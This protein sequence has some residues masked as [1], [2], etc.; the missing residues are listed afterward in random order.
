MASRATK[1]GAFAIGIFNV[2]SSQKKERFM[3]TILIFLTQ[4]VLTAIACLLIAGYIRP[5]LKR[6]LVDLCGTEERAQF[7]TVF[8]NIMLVVLPVIFGLGFYPLETGAEALFFELAGQ[9]RWNLLGLVMSLV[10]IGGAVSVFA[11]FA[12]RPKVNG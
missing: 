6:V 4:I 7:W 8:S 2:A 10:A 11:L 12:P 5:F 3:S 1:T 9:I